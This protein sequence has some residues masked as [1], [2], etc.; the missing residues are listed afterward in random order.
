[1]NLHGQ[2]LMHW[3]LNGMHRV[4]LQLPH[5]NWPLQVHLK[6]KALPQKRCH[7]RP[8]DLQALA[9]AE[10]PVAHPHLEHHRLALLRLKIYM[11]YWQSGL[12]PEQQINQSCQKIC[13][14]KWPQAI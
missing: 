1:M 5:L 8:K 4:L 12:K 2:K 13:G 9:V 10:F 7:L 6:I 14:R 3:R 11:T